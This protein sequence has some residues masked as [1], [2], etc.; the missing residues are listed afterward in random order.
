MLF[1]W[2]LGKK[3]KVK[4]GKYKENRKIDIKID[5]YDVWNLDHT[6]AMIIHPCLLELKKTKHGSPD[7]DNEDVPEEL[8]SEEH[9]LTN[10]QNILVTDSHYHKRW[11]YVLDEMIWTFKQIADGDLPLVDP[12]ERVDKGLRLFGKYYRGMWT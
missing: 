3:M 2:I 5:K 10:E 1:K 9:W 4:I 7:V 8:R 12:E 11:E 6:L